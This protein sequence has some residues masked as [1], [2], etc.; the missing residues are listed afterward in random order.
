LKVIKKNLYIPCSIAELIL[1]EPM[2]RWKRLVLKRLLPEKFFEVPAYELFKLQKGDVVGQVTVECT[3]YTD[4]T[5]E[6]GTLGLRDKC[7]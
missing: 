6:I 3:S 2:H 7:E 5:L 4:S 1:K